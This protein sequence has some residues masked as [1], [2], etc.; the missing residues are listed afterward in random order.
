MYDSAG[1]RFTLIWRF[2]RPTFRLQDH[3]AK[4]LLAFCQAAIPNPHFYPTRF[5]V[6]QEGKEIAINLALG[7]INPNTNNLVVDCSVRPREETMQ[8][9]EITDHP[10]DTDVVEQTVDDEENETADQGN[11]KIDKMNTKMNKKC[12]NRKEKRGIFKKNE[13]MFQ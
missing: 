13:K 11:F 10:T 6:I 3:K 1:H 4:S 2:C 8:V 5:L 7:M 9:S 12:R